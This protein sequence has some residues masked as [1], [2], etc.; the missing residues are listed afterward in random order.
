[1]ELDGVRGGVGGEL[2]EE[3]AAAVGLLR[4]DPL[5]AIWCRHPLAFLVEAADDICYRVVDIE[6][7]FRLGHLGYA[8]VE[9]LFFAILPAEPGQL[10]R[11][12]GLR[13]DKERV[14][15]LRAKV[16]NAAIQAVRGCF[17]D[18]EEALLAGRFDEPLLRHTPICA[19]M[20]R[21]IEVAERRIYCT[22][23]VVEV[24]AA[25]FQVIGEL[26]EGLIQVLDDIAERGAAA[27]AK[28]RM[29]QY[30]IPEQFI[31]PGRLPSDDFY[32]RLLGLTDFVA[33]MT[34]SYAV[35][36]YKKLTGISLPG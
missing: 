15:F 17:L 1:M 22:P 29:T 30:L 28:S 4:R 9:E 31:G 24:E 12:R 23:A 16:I 6:D 5:K 34:D 32:S 8:E 18:Q 35:S 20:E 11:V 19:A 21:L 10:Q 26:L 7:G 2:F 36:L 25:G 33:G 27:S 14:E 3:V 13:G